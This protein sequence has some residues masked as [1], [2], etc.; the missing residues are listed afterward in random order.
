VQILLGHAGIASTAIYTHLT[1]PTQASLHSLLDRLMTGLR[2]AAMIELGDV[3]RRFADLTSTNRVRPTDFLRRLRAAETLTV[4][5][6]PA[7]G[8]TVDESDPEN[9]LSSGY[10]DKCLI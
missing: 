8:L 7:S 4:I 1:T 2:G 9:G 6:F 10:L 5:R 3:F